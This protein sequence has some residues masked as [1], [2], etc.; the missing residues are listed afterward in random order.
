MVTTTIARSRAGNARSMSIDAHQHV[1][2]PAAS[3]SGNGADEPCQCTIDQADGDE[4]DGQRHARSPDHAAE[5]VPG[6]AVQ[7]EEV[8]GLARP[9][10]PGCGCTA[11]C[12][13]LA[14]GS[15]PS[16]GWLGSWV[17]RTGARIAIEKRKP[18]MISPITADR[19]RRMRRS[20]EL[21]ALREPRGRCR[22]PVAAP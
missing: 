9:G 10:S 14:P 4:A 17:A 19:W 22:V 5:D 13:G 20:V 18:R 11:A 1:V 21:D 15:T 6:V 7:P 2:R 3:E 12:A 16:I 8:L